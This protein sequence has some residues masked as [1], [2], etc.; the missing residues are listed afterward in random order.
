[1]INMDKLKYVDI[2]HGTGS[3][4][5][6]S[7]GNTLPLTA[8][9]HALAA[10]APQTDTSRGSWF[11]HPKDRSVEGIRLTH[12]PSPWVG[13]FSHFVFMPQRGERV[14]VDET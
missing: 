10:F 5:R 1:M 13:D 11:Y 12:Q 7:N 4:R 2:R 3:D 14:F 8:L 6:F 9:P